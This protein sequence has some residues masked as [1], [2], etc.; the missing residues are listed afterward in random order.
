MFI[1][2]FLNAVFVEISL[3]ENENFD[4]KNFI[5]NPEQASSYYEK[6]KDYQQKND[7]YTLFDFLYECPFLNIIHFEDLK[8]IK[9]ETNS[10]ILE[11]KFNK[12]TKE[13]QTKIIFDNNLQDFSSSTIAIK[14]RKLS[15]VS[16]SE[17]TIKEIL[18]E[19]K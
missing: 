5:K 15:Y 18:S 9:I 6:V 16:V 11:Y 17:K 14:L 13:Q 2:G 10:E 19:Y 4:N 3:Y 8:T 1:V 12:L 7:K